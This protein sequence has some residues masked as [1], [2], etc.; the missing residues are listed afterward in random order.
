LPFAP[1]A[2]FFNVRDVGTASPIRTVAG[3]ARRVVNRL[4]RLGVGRQRH[5]SHGASRDQKTDCSSHVFILYRFVAEAALL[6]RQAQ[7]L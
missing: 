1:D 5:G 7:S 4:S 2:Y 3:L 6:P